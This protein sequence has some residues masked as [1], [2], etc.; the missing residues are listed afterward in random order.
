ETAGTDSAYINWFKS[1][2]LQR[3]TNVPDEINL[4]DEY[5]KPSSGETDEWL[6]PGEVR[7]LGVALTL[8]PGEY[9]MK[10]TFVGNRR[11]TDFWSRIVHLH[12]GEKLPS[13]RAEVDQKQ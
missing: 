5:E 13:P 11:D 6:E 4:L 1:N 7:S 9:L 12:V 3:V 8:P 10:V 2:H